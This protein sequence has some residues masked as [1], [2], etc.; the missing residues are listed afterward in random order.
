M[1]TDNMAVLFPQPPGQLPG[2]PSLKEPRR[3]AEVGGE[4]G[5]RGNLEFPW[6]PSL[7][8]EGPRVVKTNT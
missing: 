4:P 2:K 7:Q 6:G 3:H 1:P 8:A 5:E